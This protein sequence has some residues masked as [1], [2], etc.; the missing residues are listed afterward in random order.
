MRIGQSAS[1]P[2]TLTYP[3]ATILAF[4]QLLE[5][6]QVCLSVCPFVCCSC[7]VIILDNHDIIS[8]KV[9]DIDSED[10]GDDEKDKKEVI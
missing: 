4:Q 5:S 6:L 10:N 3:R 7:N 1:M 2:Q 9:Y 8:V